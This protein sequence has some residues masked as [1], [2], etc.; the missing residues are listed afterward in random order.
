MSMKRFIVEVDHEK[1]IWMDWNW[2]IHREDDLPAIEYKDGSNIW[3]KNGVKHRVGDLPAVSF[4]DGHKE[5]WEHGKLHREVGPAI[6]KSDGT[7]FYYH[8]GEEY[9]PEK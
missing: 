7:C 9:F 5:Y 2:N 1:T 8:K 3:Y 6:I 4:P